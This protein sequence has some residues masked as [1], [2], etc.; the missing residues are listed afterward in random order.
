MGNQGNSGSSE[1]LGRMGRV[2]PQTWLFRELLSCNITGL[3]PGWTRLDTRH[4]VSSIHDTNQNVT[5]ISRPVLPSKTGF[6]VSARPL[7][8]RARSDSVQKRS[9]VLA[10]RPSS[11]SPRP[12]VSFSRPSGLFPRPRVWFQGLHQLFNGLGSYLICL[13]LMNDPG[14]EN[15]KKKH[16]W[17]CPDHDYHSPLA[18]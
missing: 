13:A 14:L 3:F 2:F 8:K 12:R 9:R 11:P 18:M 16:R 4:S 15:V 7:V 5:E 17:R 6:V 10:S 1:D